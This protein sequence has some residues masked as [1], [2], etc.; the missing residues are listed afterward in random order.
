MF[1]SSTSFMV[2]VRIYFF[3]SSR[4]RHT[5]SLCDWS[6]D[7][8]SSDLG[9]DDPAAEDHDVLRALLPEQLEDALEEVVVGAGEHAEPDRVGV[10]LDCGGDDLLGRLVEPRVDH[11]EAR[12]AQRPRDDLRPA[13]VAVEARLGDDHADRPVGRHRPCSIAARSFSPVFMICARSPGTSFQSKPRPSRIQR[14]IRGGWKSATDWQAA[15]PLAWSTLRPSGSSVCLRAMATRWAVTIAAC[16]S[17]TWASKM[18]AACALLSTRQ[19]PALSGLMS[20]IQIVRS[21]SKTFIAGVR[22]SRILQ[23]TQSVIVAS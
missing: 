11:L 14:G 10:L 15:G 20:M 21:S 8:C 9:R 7:V 2:I 6:S 1:V 22:P 16:R 19:C 5:R 3:F 4:R 12:V 13:V 17:T 23:K 18:V